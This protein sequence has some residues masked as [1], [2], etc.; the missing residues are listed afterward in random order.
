MFFTD[1]CDGLTRGLARAVLVV[2]PV[3]WGLAVEGE[4]GVLSVL[5]LLRAELD[6]AMA[7]CGF[8]S[9]AAIDRSA[10]ARPGEHPHP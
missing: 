7:F 10:I 5:K 1:A 4:A 3:L 6:R 9:V 8:T 2:R